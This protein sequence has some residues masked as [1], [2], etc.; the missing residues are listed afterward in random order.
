MMKAALGGES[1][2]TAGFAHPTGAFPAAM[3]ASLTAVIIAAHVGAE[4]DVPPTAQRLPSRYTWKL[5]LH[6]GKGVATRGEQLHMRPTQAKLT[7][8]RRRLDRH[9][10][11]D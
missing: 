1:G 9:V 3:R 7:H 4:A 11:S 5:R 10:Q 8:S 2:R 6:K